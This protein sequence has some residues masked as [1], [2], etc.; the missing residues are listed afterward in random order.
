LEEFEK[1]DVPIK[2]YGYNSLFTKL[3]LLPVTFL[4]LTGFLLKT[5][6]DIVITSLSE[7]DIL[8]YLVLG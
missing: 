5:K 4:R 8:D 2:I 7:A 3:L 1:F 6:P